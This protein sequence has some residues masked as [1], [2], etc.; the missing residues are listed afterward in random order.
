MLVKK[1]PDIQFCD[2]S[3]T[4]QL[5]SI[6]LL[7]AF[8][9]FSSFTQA[10]IMCDCF[11]ETNKQKSSDEQLDQMDDPSFLTVIISKLK[12]EC[13]GQIDHEI[14]NAIL[15]I[16]TQVVRNDDSNR[17][18][19]GKMFIKEIAGQRLDN[20]I[21]YSLFKAKQ[22]FE[23]DQQCIQKYKIKELAAQQ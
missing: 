9:S 11:D 10:L 6:R 19:I 5:L 16:L 1:G 22:I 15:S 21:E 2:F 20:L 12:P 8:I 18:T 13:I 14:E 4:I 17:K 3:K 23:K 7:R